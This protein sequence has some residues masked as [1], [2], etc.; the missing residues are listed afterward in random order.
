MFLDAFNITDQSDKQ[1]VF[2]NTGNWQVWYK[3]RWVKVVQFFV[4]WAWGGWASGNTWTAWGW[5]GWSGS[6]VSASVLASLLPDTLYIN[7]WAGWAGWVAIASLSGNTWATGW[8]SS[9]SIQPNT[10]A[11]NVLFSASGWVG[12]NGW[13]GGS[14]GTWWAWWAAFVTGNGILSCFTDFIS[15]AWV[16]WNNGWLAAGGSVTALASSIVT[17]WA[18]WWGSWAGWDITGAWIVPTI[19]WGTVWNGWNK[20]FQINKPFITTWGSWCGGNSTA[21]WWFG[22]L[23]SWWGW[24]SGRAGTSWAWGNG[25]D[26][27][28]MIN[29]I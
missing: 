4:L 20:W 17:W 21:V 9:I 28:I 19:A 13:A 15:I 3:P 6:I 5:G 18:G 2:T 11:A 12:W 27:I 25:W 24:G 7:V 16:S 29:C 1:R 8:A 26:G 10:T 23:G 22:W 14:A